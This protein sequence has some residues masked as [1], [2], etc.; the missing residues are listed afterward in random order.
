VGECLEQSIMR[1]RLLSRALSSP[2]PPYGTPDVRLPT[3][4][5]AI[6]LFAALG[7]GRSA[8]ESKIEVVAAPLPAEP[9][10]S[11]EALKSLHKRASD[12]I[13]LKQFETA[14]RLLGEAYLMVERLTPGDRMDAAD[15]LNN[16]GTLETA[17]LRFDLASGYLSKAEQMYRRI[18]QD[19]HPLIVNV[20][21]NR[22]FVARSDDDLLNADRLEREAKEMD[23]RLKAKSK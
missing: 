3:H 6:I 12:A 2:I 23:A 10:D 16:F 13:R 1:S 20:L 14:E 4:P 18:L 22:A 21:R 15:V 17:R 7:C 19:D 8:P 9:A 5:F 11:R